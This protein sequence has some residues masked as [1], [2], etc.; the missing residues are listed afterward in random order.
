MY[1]QQGGSRCYISA[2]VTTIPGLPYSYLTRTVS[3]NV[4]DRE[5]AHT[6]PKG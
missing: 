6:E 5:L 4:H 1:E 2:N 3:S